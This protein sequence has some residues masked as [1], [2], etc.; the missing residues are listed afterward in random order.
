M[1]DIEKEISDAWEE[2]TTMQEVADEGIFRP[3]ES[4]MKRAFALVRDISWNCSIIPSE[5]S[6]HVRAHAMLDKLII[7]AGSDGSVDINFDDDKRGSICVRVLPGEKSRY[8]YYGD[9]GTRS[10]PSTFT[11]S[12]EISVREDVADLVVFFFKEV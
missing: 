12:G 8:V 4:T 10:R 11:V 2:F 6:D 9:N 3:D 1:I 5:D 7:E